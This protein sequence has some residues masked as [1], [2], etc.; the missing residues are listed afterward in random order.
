MSENKP[1]IVFSRNYHSAAIAWFCPNYAAA[2]ERWTAQHSLSTP[3]LIATVGR[4][5]DPSQPV[6]DV[7]E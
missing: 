4:V 6:I 5:I 1:H 3:Y 7:S 2:Y